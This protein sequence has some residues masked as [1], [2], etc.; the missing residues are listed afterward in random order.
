MLRVRMDRAVAPPRPTGMGNAARMA[1]VPSGETLR[2]A[3]RWTSSPSN[4]KIVLK[5]A[6]Q[7]RSA[8]EAIASNTGWMSVCA[9]LMTRRISPVAVC[10]SSDSARSVFLASSSLNSRTF[11][12]AMTAWSAKVCRSAT[13]RS[14]KAPGSRRDTTMAPI[15]SPSRSIGTVNRFR[16]P[17]SRPSSREISRAE[18]S[19]VSGTSNTER[20]RIAIPGVESMSTGRGYRARTAASASGEPPVS[21]LRWSIPPSARYTRAVAPL[22]SRRALLTIVSNTGWTSV[23]ELEITRRISAVAVCCSSVSVS[24][25]V[26]A[27]TFCSRLA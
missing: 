15:A 16:I 21:A 7:S 25:R 10:C 4:L 13:S 19:S 8:L 26:R 12:M 23:G 14:A 2:S 5:V 20:V 3:S 22:Q 18:G 9:L 11:S 1:A 17:N 27:S 6:S 24:S